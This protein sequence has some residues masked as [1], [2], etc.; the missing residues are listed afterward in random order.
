LTDILK[1]IIVKEMGILTSQKITEYYERYKSIEVTFTKEIIQVTRM[2]T[3]QVYLKCISDFW[4]CIVFSSSFQSAKVVVNIKSGIIEKLRQANNSAS[5]RLCFKNDDSN[6]PVT[7]F[8]SA[9]SV[10]YTPYGNSKDVAIF[11]LQFTQ[12]PPDDLIEI[13]GRLLDANVNSTKRREERVLLTADSVRKLRLLSKETASFIQG[14]PRRCILRDLSFSG[15]KLI[16]MGGAKFLVDKESALR[17]DFDDPRESYLIR[18]KFI[19][20]EPVE[21]RKELLALVMLFNETMVP[22][23]Y[24]MRLNDFVCQIRVDNRGGNLQSSEARHQPGNT[25]GAVPAPGSGQPA[26]QGHP[27]GETPQNKVLEKLTSETT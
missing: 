2:I 5:L 25:A 16:M 13:M 10:G 19:R 22:M 1:T 8:V 24:K 6:T 9:R 21:G 23:G 11:T 27:P 14:V 26:D 17:I 15:A 12:R 7:F 18:G 20:A 3:Q 4:P